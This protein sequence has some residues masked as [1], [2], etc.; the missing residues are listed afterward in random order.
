MKKMKKRI[1]AYILALVM[2]VSLLPGAI[3]ATETTNPIDTEEELLAAIEADPYGTIKLGGNIILSYEIVLRNGD[4]TIDLNGYNLTCNEN[5][6]LIT[7]DCGVLIIKGDGVVKNASGSY[8]IKVLSDEFGSWASKVYV[9]GGTFEAAG[10][11]TVGAAIYVGNAAS[12]IIT[13]GTFRNGFE[14]EDG[15]RMVYTLYQLL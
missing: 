13:G 11:D 14:V 2:I 6:A 10:G 3:F 7:V 5:E 9:K 4:L 8:A 1:W 12:A 15:E